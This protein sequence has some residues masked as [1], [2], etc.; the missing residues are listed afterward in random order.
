M[1]TSAL[2]DD[3]AELTQRSCVHADE[4]KADIRRIGFVLYPGC[5]LIDFAGATQIF[6]FSGFECVWYAETLD[7]ITTSEGIQVQPRVDFRGNVLAS[8]PFGV[9]EPDPLS[10][11]VVFVPGGGGQGVA[12]SMKNPAMLEFLRTSSSQ[13]HWR[14]S[15]CVGAFILWA[16]GVLCK[17]SATTYWSLVPTL[18]TIAT[19]EVPPYFPRWDLNEKRR[20]FTGGG[21]SSSM[22]LALD[23]VRRF[24]GPKVAKKGQLSVQYQP[25]PPVDSGDPTVASPVLVNEVRAHQEEDFI[26][27]IREA[28]EE[29]QAGGGPC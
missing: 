20:I 19:L 5:T 21:A 12:D 24:A 17:T 7:P 27:P 14:G 22:D 23:L 11:D 29:I 18:E 16:S 4:L 9:D 28:V 26:G 15:V 8:A 6:A 2:P 3:F 1:T 25:R 10:I 13:A